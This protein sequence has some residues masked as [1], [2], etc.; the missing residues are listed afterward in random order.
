MS[1]FDHTKYS[2]AEYAYHGGTF[3]GNALT[4]A[5]GLA[6]ID[7]LEHSPVYEHID[8]LGSQLRERLTTIFET[9]AFPAQVT[10]LGSLFAIHT[11]LKRPLRDVRSYSLHD[12]K[13]SAS[14][15][16]YLLDNGI[17]LL[18]PEMLH[19]CISYAHTESDVGRLTSTMEQYV[20]R[21]VR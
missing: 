5:A 10:G 9:A 20:N 3:S 11:T 4:L 8:R 14:I 17:L 18:T 12:H 21:T 13:Q 19:G 7:V 2:S 16:T 15:F 6:T 1:H